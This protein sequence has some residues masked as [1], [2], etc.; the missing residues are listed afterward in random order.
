VATNPQLTPAEFARKWRGIQT[1]ERASAQ[2]HFM[3]LCRMLGEPTPHEADPTGE[4]FALGKGAGKLGGGEGFADVWKRGFFAWEYKAEA[5][6][7]GRPIGN[8]W[9]TRT[10]WRTRRSLW[11]P[12]S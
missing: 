11:F 3:D 9:T 1:G 2:S 10:R 8:W 4:W 5:R 6:T 7:C 12:T